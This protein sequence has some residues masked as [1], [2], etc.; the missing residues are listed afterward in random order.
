MTYFILS[1][2]FVNQYN[3]YVNGVN[4]LDLIP[5]NEGNYY[6]STNAQSIFPELDFSEFEI[7]TINEQ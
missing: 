7:I 3:G 2:E 6:L 4:A 5:D 1:I